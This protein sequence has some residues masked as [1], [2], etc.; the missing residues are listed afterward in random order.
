MY[1]PRTS[2]NVN[3]TRRIVLLSATLLVVASLAHAQRIE[4]SYWVETGEGGQCIVD[5]L[6]APFNEKSETIHVVATPQPNF[7]D[8]TRTALAGGGG[9]DVVGTPGPSFVFELARAGQLLSLEEYAEQFGWEDRFFGWALNLG[10]VDG[11]LYSLPDEVETLLLYYNKTLFEKHGWELP[12]T[13]DELVDLAGTIADAG[14]IPF[15][16]SNTEWRPANEW[17]VGEFLNQV[18]GPQLV[19]EALVGERPWTDPAFVRAIE[20]LDMMQQ[21]GWFMG[22]LDR[23]YTAM[24]DERRVVFGDGGAAMVI[25]GSWAVGS[26]DAFFGEEAGNANEWDWIPVPSATGEVYFTV[27]L[28]HTVSINRNASNPDAA[29]EFLTYFFSSEVQGRRLVECGE[30]PAPVRIDIEEFLGSDPRHTRV[31]EALDAAFA[32]GNFGYTTWTFFP[33]RTNVYIWEEIERV[34][35]GRL[36]PLQYLEGMQALHEQERAAGD[37]LIVPAR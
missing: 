4:L 20:I 9:P 16:H 34:W 6:V 11:T 21:E 32:L 27:G 35:A 36:T 12:T 23:Y 18:A 25:E 28:G 15:A 30:D 1:L 7:W 29:A 33:P 22:G 19:Y 2:G 26:H 14:I 24:T 37:T 31:V 10:R 5:H 8:A 3:L 17:F 13:M